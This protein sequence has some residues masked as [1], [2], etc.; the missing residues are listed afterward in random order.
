MPGPN[1]LLAALSA[2]LVLPATA[3]AQQADRLP[4]DPAVTVGTLPNG[5]RYYIRQNGRPENRAELRLVVKAGSILE[6][7]DQLGLAH[8]VEHMAFNGTKNFPEAELVRYLEGIGMRFGPDLNAYTSFDETVYMLQVPTDSDATVHT[9]FQI[10]EDWAHN[11]SFDPAQIEKE[12][13]VVMEEWRLGQGA[14][15][16]LRKQ[17]FPTLFHGSRYAERLPIGTPDVLR[18]FTHDR[19]TRF[20][21]DWYRPDLMAVIAVGDF[22]VAAIEALIREHFGRIAAPQSPRPRPTFDMPGH[23]ETM[24]AVATDPE[25]TGTQVEID[26]KLP[27]RERNTLRGYRQTL[28]GQLY[29]RMLNARFAEITQKPNPPFIGAGTNYGAF[30]GS[31]EMYSLGAAVETGGVERGLEALLTESQRVRQHGFTATELERDKTNVLRAYERSYAERERTES[32]RLAAEYVRAFLQDEAFPGI[33]AEYALVQQLLPGIQLAEINAL[34]Q[35]FSPDDNRVIIVTA[36][37]RADVPVPTEESLLAVV[38]R[39]G[40]VQ[41]AAYEDNVLDQPLVSAPPQP[42]RIVAERAVPGIDA[43]LLELS[44]GARVYLMRTDHRHDQVLLGAWSPGGLSLLSDE[45]YASGVFAPQL[46]AL[47]GLGEF[48]AVQLERALTGKAASVQAGPGEYSES[49]SGTAS[50][51]DLKTLFQLTYL[52]FTAPRNDADAYDS[53]MSRIRAALA[54]RDANPQAAFSDTF[55]ITLWQNH[56]RARPQTVAWFDNVDREA[57][58][59]IFRERF[60]DAGDF[61]FA[62]VGAF[63]EAAIRPLIEQYIASLPSRGQREQPRDN[64]M[65]PVRGV[66]EKVVRRGLEPRAQTRITFTGEF[67]YTRE[68]RLAIS[69][70]RDVVDIRLRDVLREDLGGTYGVSVSQGTQRFPDGRYSF[71]IQFGSAPDRLEELTAAVFA[72]IEALGQ[73]GPD[74]E[75]LARVKEQQRRGY[76]TSVQRNEYWL[77]VLLREAETGEPAASAQ[78]FPQRVDAVTAAQIRDGAR[79]WFDMGNYVRVSLIPER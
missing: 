5:L 62:F 59:R 74:A 76:E 32:A 30:I 39:A 17:Y 21:R 48:D 19:L 60:A 43:Q 51:Q 23:A 42:G 58:Y 55:A 78:E 38:Q 31:G 18:N 68:N 77:S 29:T 72:E 36:P 56:P 14:G 4:A 22:D 7:E 67:D 2:L 44:N 66:V 54:N 25:A 73:N 16:R 69:L 61:T 28:M 37:E 3:A 57:A 8:F 63:D 27:S 75:T 41:L 35:Q 79:R 26:W 12:R 1:W 15:E 33:A 11:V 45:A 71:S 13:G 52:H 40:G 20:Y 64:G 65:R 34:A 49:L 53:F 9:A 70:L 50:P 10:L 24:V 6:D 47:S 46:I